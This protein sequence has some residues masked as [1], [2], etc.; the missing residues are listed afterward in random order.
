MGDIV[1]SALVQEGVSGV[2]S[3]VSSKLEEK[4]SR[5]HLMVRLE[6]ALSRLEFALE[7]TGKMPI[8]YVSLLRRRKVL[9]QAYIE[10]TDL[11]NKHKLQLVEHDKETEQQAKFVTDVESSNPLQH[12]TFCYPLV[13]QLLEGK[14]FRYEMVK[15]SRACVLSLWPVCIEDRGVEARFEYMYLDT[16]RP[17]Q[18]FLLGLMLRLSEDTDIVGIAT[19]CLQLLTSQFKLV[20]ESAVGELTLLPHL[21]DISHTHAVPRSWTEKC[22]NITCTNVTKFLRPDPICCANNTVLSDSSLG[23]PEPVIG[24]YLEYMLDSSAYGVG[25]KA[26]PLYL[27]AAFAP[28]TSAAQQGFL[29][30]NGVKEE[31]IGGSIQQMEE[32]LRSKAVDCV[33]RQPQPTDGYLFWSSLHGVAFITLHRSSNEPACP[34]PTAAHRRR[35]IA[36]EHGGKEV[37][38][39]GS[40]EQMEEAVKSKTLDRVIRQLEPTHNAVRWYYRDI[41]AR[42]V[43]SELSNT[44]PIC[45]RRAAKRKR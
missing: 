2:S 3:Y 21:Q 4:A 8:T 27:L 25:S 17:E 40:I 26:P 29:F 20:T 1:A 16:E 38:I 41:T 28:H 12:D 36:F 19:K 44:A 32:I 33:F 6:M 39:G 34:K 42:I 45:N 7:R 35:R 11:L 14:P 15:E 18:C 43:T 37:F 30:K 22:A 5:A 13:R 9:K 31:Y 10:G 24:V 23:F